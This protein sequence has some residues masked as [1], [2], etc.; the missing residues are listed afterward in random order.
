MMLVA[1]VPLSLT[2]CA[3]GGSSSTSGNEESGGGG[4]LTL[5]T[6]SAGNKNEL[7]SIKTIVD[8]FNA[9]Q[10]KYKV[11]VQAFPQESYNQSVA[12]AAAAKKLPC[13]LDIDGPN[14]PNW[15]WAGYLAPLEGMDDVLSKYLP[16]TVGKYKDKYYS[17]GYFDVA[18]DMTSRKSVLKKYGIRVPT[19]DQPW[20]R[21]EFM[22]GLKKIKDSGDF[23]NPLD[24]ATG[25]T[26]EWWPYAYSPLLQSFGGD[27]INRNDYK[28][29]EGVLNGAK[30]LAWAAWFRGLVNRQAN[31]VEVR[32]RSG[33]GLPQ[34]QD[35]HLL[36]R[37]VGSGGRPQEVRRRHRVP[38]AARL[39]QR[40]EDRRR[41]PGSGACPPTAVTTPRAL[42][43]T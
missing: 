8:D 42:W 41:R 15:A 23:V 10:T 14:V 35:R 6:H 3:K 11:E 22:A 13:I 30:A 4:T 7:A 12:A 24:I 43:S 16:S 17:Y 38:A 37:H 1:A 36:Q 26:G 20:T 40:P 28:S 39:R 21:D 29:A 19:V 9:S 34:R 2:A 33:Q 5:W 31:A 32:R 18:L 25:S 27:L